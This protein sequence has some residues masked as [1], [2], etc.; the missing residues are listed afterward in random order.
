[1][2]DQKNFEKKVFN[3]TH[4]GDSKNLSLSLSL[5]LYCAPLSHTSPVSSVPQFRRPVAQHPNVIPAWSVFSHSSCGGVGSCWRKDGEAGKTATRLTLDA[6]VRSSGPLQQ[7]S[8]PTPE[9]LSLPFYPLFCSK[10][11]LHSSWSVFHSSLV[12]CYMP[13]PSL[14]LAL[15]LSCRSLRYLG[16]SLPS[17]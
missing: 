3:K 7:G 13:P 14:H 1:M 2:K 4:K 8:L 11:L 12:L 5:A 6:S 16:F 10:L 15:P 9:S 17:S